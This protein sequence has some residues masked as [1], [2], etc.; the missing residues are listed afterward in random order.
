MLRRY[1]SRLL[2]ACS[3]LIMGFVA[4][5]LSMPAATLHA[6]QGGKVYELRTYTAAEGKMDAV[7]ARF[8]DHTD[9]IFSKHGMKS[10]GY[11]TPTDPP[12][13]G[14]TLIYILEHK[15]RD[16]A[17]ASWAA[18]Q[19][20]PEWQKAKAA[21]EAQGRIVT[22]AESVFMTTTDYSPMK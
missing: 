22:K 3:L 11:W 1:S 20:D 4:G 8:R 17:K 13:A 12:L 16:A 7:N 9:K 18:F 14:S 10:I 19:A 15:S 21:S 5:R 2:L 6:E